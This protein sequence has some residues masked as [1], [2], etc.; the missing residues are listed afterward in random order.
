[1]LDT[2]AKIEKSVKKNVTLDDEDKKWLN[3]D[4]PS[5]AK[6]K[7]TSLFAEIRG[8]KVGHSLIY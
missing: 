8:K 1:M 4:M 5:F 7:A 3:Q 2:L 6:Y